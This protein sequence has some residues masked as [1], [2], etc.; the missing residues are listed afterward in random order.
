MRILVTGHLGYVGTAIVPLL[1]GAGHE[2]T[3]LD[4]NLFDQNTL[5]QEPVPVKQMIKDIRDVRPADL[6][7]FDAVLHL[8]ALC[9]DPLGALNPDITY[10]INYRATISLAKMAKAAGVRRFLFSSSCAI[11]GSAGEEMLTES[12]PFNPVTAYGWSKV[13]AERDLA[14][15]ADAHFAP[16][17]L[18]NATAYGFAPRLRLD[19]V[20]NDLVASAY[21]TQ[22]I[23]LQSD[24]TPWRPVVHVEDIGSAALAVL[25]APLEAV[26]TEAFNVGVDDDNYQVIELAEIVKDVVG[27]CRI[28][29]MPGAGPDKRCYRVSFRKMLTRLPEF[30]ARWNARRGAQQLYDTFRHLGLSQYDY[31]GPRFRRVL[32]VR[33]LLTV[34]KLNCELRRAGPKPRPTEQATTAS[35]H[36]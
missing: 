6:E 18:R 19:I 25:N 31:T 12:A 20:L 7:G 17:Y 14:E 21:T 10:D 3:G 16:T 27:G 28:E 33:D 24:G 2:V 26:S 30:K 32:Q 22:R 9:N 34:G 4:A 5:G 29:F 1:V 13:L 23:L 36:N 11:Y 8:A 35:Y 15:L